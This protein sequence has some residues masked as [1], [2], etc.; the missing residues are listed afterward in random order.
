[1]PKVT[2]DDW[3]VNYSWT[4][5]SGLRLGTCEYNGSRVL[6]T[7][8]VPFIYVNYAGKA[9]GPFT[10]QLRSTKGDVELREIMMGFDLRVTYDF[11]GEDYQ[12]SHIWRFQNDGQFGSTIVIH[13]P[14]EEING[15][16]TYH[17]P[18]RFDL[19][20]NG[21][22]GD[23]FQRWVPLG[24]GMGLWLDVLLEGQHMPSS[25]LAPATYDW[26]VID[27]ATSKRA[28][29]RAGE[30]DNGEI[31][32]LR[33]SDLESWNSW[34]GALASPPGSPGS[35]PSIYNNHQSVQNTDVVIWYISHISSR[36][37][38]AT[39]GPWFKLVGFNAGHV[40]GTPGKGH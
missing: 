1:M 4:T 28:M 7:A 26:Q 17:V 27:K 40:P 22:S 37:L 34:G 14:G 36:D 38:I 18:F 30:H 5:S 3:V 20:V 9:F 24:G 10:D 29:I 15:Q 12:Y 21:A 13:G 39:C 11:Y 2:R 33:Y 8:S 19:D 35:V 31:W 16:H 6:H 32:A 23:S 25:L